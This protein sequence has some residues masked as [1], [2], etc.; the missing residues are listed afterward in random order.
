MAQNNICNC[1]EPSP[2]SVCGSNVNTS[3]VPFGQT[4]ANL[5]YMDKVYS[6]NKAAACPI[7]EA[8][9]AD[10]EWIIET[11][12]SADGCGAVCTDRNCVEVCGS[13]IYVCCNCGSQ[14]DLTITAD[15]VFTVTK[16]YVVVN[17]IE[18]TD[19]TLTAAD[20]TVDGIAVDTLTQNGN[21]YTASTGSLISQTSRKRC[22]ELGLPSKNFFLITGAGPWTF[23][24]TIVLEGTVNTGG[25]SGCFRMRFTTPEAGIAVTGESTFAVPKLAL[26]CAVD[27]ASPTIGFGFTSQ[28]Y[29]LNPTVTAAAG[30]SGAVTLSLAASLVLQPQ[31]NVEVVRRTLFCLNA[32]EAIMPCDGTEEACTADMA[33]DC[34]CNPVRMCRCGTAGTATITDDVCDNAA[35]SCGTESCG[36]KSDSGCA[37][38]GSVRRAVPDAYQWLGCSGCSW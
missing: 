22:M 2:C 30:E 28:A 29:V 4:E 38:S 25:K 13:K 31:L 8:V 36:E 37:C 27:G 23:R 20:V 10:T 9:P 6:H 26:P 3:G 32:C 24:G 16:S 5:V 11:V 12:L 34:G 19:G 35:A 17:G 1:T 15:A 7:L 33:D 21:R 18:L 14:G